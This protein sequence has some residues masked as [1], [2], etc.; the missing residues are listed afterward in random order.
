[1][2]YRPSL[3]PG[4]LPFAVEKGEFVCLLVPDHHRERADYIRLAMRY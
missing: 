2:K 1:M 3:P 4:T